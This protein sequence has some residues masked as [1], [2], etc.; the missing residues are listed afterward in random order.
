MTRLSVL[1]VLFFIINA[2][3]A[4]SQTTAC[5]VGKQR[6]GGGYVFQCAADGVHG[7]QAALSDISVSA[8]WSTANNLC[9]SYGWRLPSINELGEMNK[10]IKGIANFDDEYWSADAS[11][12]YPCGYCGDYGKCSL[13]YSFSGTYFYCACNYTYYRVRCVDNF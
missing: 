8:T 4:F 7:T 11:G 12:D 5:E 6:I 2:S 3:P 1:M 9:G 10:T 13:Y